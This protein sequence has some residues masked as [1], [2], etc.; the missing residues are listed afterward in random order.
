[1]ALISGFFNSFSEINSYSFDVLVK[2]QGLDE[3]SS[4][5]FFMIEKFEDTENLVKKLRSATTISAV[6]GYTLLVKY[7]HV[8]I[9]FYDKSY[10]VVCL[11]VFVTLYGI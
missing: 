1:M 8:D 10:R 2:L 3:D 9:L 4:S 6:T 5:R 11:K 7:R